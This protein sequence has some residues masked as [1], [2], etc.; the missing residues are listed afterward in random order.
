MKLI[1]RVDKSVM[2]WLITDVVESK[3]TLFLVGQ[4]EVFIHE[5]D[6]FLTDIGELLETSLKN[7]IKRV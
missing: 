1:G 4:L 2:L 3:Q 6:W 7:I 5:Y